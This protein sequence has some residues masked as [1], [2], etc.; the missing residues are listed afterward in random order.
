VVKNHGRAKDFGLFDESNGRRRVEQMGGSII[1]LPELDGVAMARI[2]RN[3]QSF[4]SAVNE[5]SGEHALAPLQRERTRLWLARC[6]KAF[7]CVADAL[8]NARDAAAPNA[9]GE[10]LVANGSAN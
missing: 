5:A 8:G 3:G 7:G 4:W 2:D 6:Y 10:P 9:Q 1:E